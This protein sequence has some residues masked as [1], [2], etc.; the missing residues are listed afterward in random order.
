MGDEQGPFNYQNG[1]LFK[2]QE[3]VLVLAGRGK[4]DRQAR[5]GVW[6]RMQEQVKKKGQNRDVFYKEILKDLMIDWDGG[7][8][9]QRRCQ[10]LLSHFWHKHLGKWRCH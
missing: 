7:S 1:V 3:I 2:F 6:T 5:E 4:S 10:K 8:V 9:G